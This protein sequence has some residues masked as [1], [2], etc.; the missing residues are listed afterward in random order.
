MPPTPPLSLADLEIPRTPRQARALSEKI[1]AWLPDPLVVETSQ[2]PV[3]FVVEH[4]PRPAYSALDPLGCTGTMLFPG[5]FRP[6]PRGLEYPDGWSLD[7]QRRAM[8]ALS[9]AWRDHPAQAG[10]LAAGRLLA[11]YER[12]VYG[13]FDEDTPFAEIGA[14]V[15]DAVRRPLLVVAAELGRE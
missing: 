11:S 9:D 8:A 3:T 1:V 4:G 6:Y 7:D 2:G 12:C 10:L 13:G 14:P 5:D 15:E